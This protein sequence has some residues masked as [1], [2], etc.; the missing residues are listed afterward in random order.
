MISESVTSRLPF[1]SSP[2]DKVC[3]AIRMADRAVG[4]LCWSALCVMR[5]ITSKVRGWKGKIAVK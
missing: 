3:Q 2:S 1:S 5:R 4:R